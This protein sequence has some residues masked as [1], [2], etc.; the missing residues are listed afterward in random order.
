M[1][2]DEDSARARSPAASPR[3]RGAFARDEACAE[4]EPRDAQTVSDDEL[5]ARDNEPRDE[6]AARDDAPRGDRA[7]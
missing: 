7:R 6:L 3:R 2:T 5:T 4:T 1:E